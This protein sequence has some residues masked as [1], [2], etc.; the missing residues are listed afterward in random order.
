M[1]ISLYKNDITSGLVM[2]EFV[3]MML[4]VPVMGMAFNIIGLPPGATAFLGMIVPM[5]FMQY[6]EPM[7]DESGSNHDHHHHHG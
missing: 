6:I 1:T 5:F 4:A 7:S 2:S 3:R